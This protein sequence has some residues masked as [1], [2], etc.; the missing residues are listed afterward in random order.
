MTH[1]W[2]VMILKCKTLYQPNLAWF[3]GVGT[4][5]CRKKL[6]F[7]PIFG[8]LVT[9]FTFFGPFSLYKTYMIKKEE[10]IGNKNQSE[11][12][13]SHWTCFVNIFYTELSAKRVSY[14]EY[15]H[16][17]IYICTDGWNMENHHLYSKIN[18][19]STRFV[20]ALFTFFKILVAYY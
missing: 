10:T 8:R 2:F 3:R 7:L 15:C 18:I 19:F 9:I 12:K 4:E 20:T 17:Y 11:L 1:I 5:N 13:T 16:I 14:L 6:C